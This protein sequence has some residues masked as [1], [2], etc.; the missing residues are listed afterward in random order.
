MKIFSTKHINSNQKELES[1]K[2]F[3]TDYKVGSDEFNFHLSNYLKSRIEITKKL[4]TSFPNSKI[5][6]KIVSKMQ[7]KEINEGS[8]I[9]KKG[10]IC[11]KFYFLLKGEC[12]VLDTKSESAIASSDEIEYYLKRLKDVKEYGLI[13]QFKK[14]NPELSN[15]FINNLFKSQNVNAI[16]SNNSLSGV[17]KERSTSK[18]PN[19]RDDLFQVD[20]KD[21]KRKG[22][23]QNF[24]N[25]LSTHDSLISAIRNYTHLSE[26]SNKD[27]NEVIKEALFSKFFTLEENELRKWFNNEELI[28]LY[29]ESRK[30]EN[31]IDGFTPA[32]DSKDGNKKS[33][34][35]SSM[36][37]NS[38]IKK[39]VINT[40]LTILE[41]F[42][43]KRLEK[44]EEMLNQDIETCNGNL[45]SKASVSKIISKNSVL[46]KDKMRSNNSSILGSL[47]KMNSSVKFNNINLSSLKKF[48]SRI[49]SVNDENCIEEINE[50][51]CDKA[52]NITLKYNFINNQNV[53]TD[54]NPYKFISGNNIASKKPSLS[55]FKKN[56][57][58]KSGFLNLTHSNENNEQNNNRNSYSNTKFNE[59]SLFKKVRKS[60][61]L[62]YLNTTNKNNENKKVSFYQSTSISKIKDDNKIFRE[63]LSLE[64]K[65]SINKSN[66]DGSLFF[67]LN[68]IKNNSSDDNSNKSDSK[69]I[70]FETKNTN[71]KEI[72]FN[73]I[74][75]ERN[76]SSISFHKHNKNKINLSNSISLNNKE[77]SK[78]FEK[79]ND[80]FRNK[81]NSK[82]PS[83]S[84][85]KLLSLNYVA[86]QELY[87]KR[88]SSMLE[89][90]QYQS[91]IHTSMQSFFNL[92]NLYNSKSNAK[93]IP[94]PGT[95][96]T[97]NNPRKINKSKN[98]NTSVDKSIKQ[99]ELSKSPIKKK[100]IFRGKNTNEYAIDSKLIASSLNKNNDETQLNNKDHD[101]NLKH[102]FNKISYQIKRII[103]KDTTFPEPEMDNVFYNETIISNSP[104]VMGY[105]KKDDYFSTVFL[106]INEINKQIQVSLST[107][108]LFINH[109][110]G[111]FY[112]SFQLL[113]GEFNSNIITENTDSNDYIYLLKS[114]QCCAEINI[115]L[116]DLNNFFLKLISLEAKRNIYIQEQ[117]LLYAIKHCSTKGEIDCL[118]E[119]LS[120]FYS[121][122]GKNFLFY[123]RKNKDIKPNNK[124]TK[125]NFKEDQD[126]LMDE[127]D[128]YELSKNA[129]NPKKGLKRAYIN[130]Y[131]NFDF[132]DKKKSVNLSEDVSYYSEDNDNENTISASRSNQKSTSLNYNVRTSAF[133]SNSINRYTSNRLVFNGRVK[134]NHLSSKNKDLH[135][136]THKNQENNDF[137][138]YQS[139]ISSK[140][141]NLKS[142]DISNEYFTSNL[143]N[144]ISSHNSNLKEKISHNLS[145]IQE[146]R[147]QALDYIIRKNLFSSSN[148]EYDDLL[149]EIEKT[150]VFEHQLIKLHKLRDDIPFIEEKETLKLYLISNSEFFNFFETECL[151][152]L[153]LKKILNVRCLKKS[154]YLRIQKKDFVKFL[155]FN[156]EIR[157]RAFDY[158]YFKILSVFRRMNYLKFQKL[159][160]ISNTKAHE[161]T[162][163]K[164]KNSPFNIKNLNNNANIIEEGNNN[165]IALF[166]KN[167]N[168]TDG[169]YSSFNIDYKNYTFKNVK[170]KNNT[171]V[172][173]AKRIVNNKIKYNPALTNFDYSFIVQR[174]SKDKD[175]SRLS[176]DLISKEDYTQENRKS[177]G[178]SNKVSHE[179]TNNSVDEITLKTYASKLSFKSKNTAKKIKK[180]IKIIN[181]KDKVEKKFNN[182][183][184]EAY[185]SRLNFIKNIAINNSENSDSEYSDNKGKNTNRSL[186]SQTRNKTKGSNI[187]KKQL[188]IKDLKN[189]FNLTN[190]KQNKMFLRSQ[191]KDIGSILISSNKNIDTNYTNNAKENFYF[192]EDKNISN[193]IRFKV[194]KGVGTS[195]DN[196]ETQFKITNLALVQKDLNK[197][198]KLA[199]K[200]HNISSIIFTKKTKNKKKKAKS[201]ANVV[202]K[203]KLYK[204]VDESDKEFN[205]FLKDLFYDKQL[206]KR[207]KINKSS[208]NFYLKHRRNN[209]NIL[210]ALM[211]NTSYNNSRSKC[212]SRNERSTT[213]TKSFLNIN[214]SR[215][216]LSMFSSNNKSTEKDVIIENSNSKLIFPN[217]QEPL[218]SQDTT[219]YNF[220]YDK[221]EKIE[222]NNSSL[223]NCIN[224]V[225][226]KHG[227]VNITN[228]NNDNINKNSDS[229]K[230]VFSNQQIN[231]SKFLNLQNSISINNL[232]S[233][234]ISDLNPSTFLNK[235]I[236]SNNLMRGKE[237]YSKSINFNSNN[238]YINEDQY[239]IHNYAHKSNEMDFQKLLQSRLQKSKR[240]IFQL[241]KTLLL[242]SGSI[243][244]N[245]ILL[246]KNRNSK[247]FNKDTLSQSNSIINDNT[248]SYNNNNNNSID[249]KFIL[250]TELIRSL[251]KKI[252]NSEK[253]MRDRFSYNFDSKTEGSIN[254]SNYKKPMNVHLNDNILNIKKKIMNNMNTSNTNNTKKGISLNFNI[255]IKNT[256]ENNKDKKNDIVKDKK[257]SFP[258]IFNK[259]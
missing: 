52:N 132:I 46:F 253:K 28:D 59:E 165:N 177:I 106:F 185:E 69:R 93:L 176:Y 150:F 49:M 183:Y 94:K 186:N 103:S 40:F 191:T 145:Y 211:S 138:P 170:T 25:S 111:N 229:D 157:E 115:S 121:K 258:S 199:S 75:D 134:N 214:A 239:F 119:D 58:Q 92:T 26:S 161:N 100:S 220:S 99:S 56:S 135:I 102:F 72:F 205:K 247:D 82:S 5:I 155:G 153:G 74:K 9:F 174:D 256:N 68:E 8:V 178:K 53:G 242:K 33:Y 57:Q 107:H 255:N 162:G 32:S 88:R 1:I 194:D 95:S 78:A 91:E 166:S 70:R 34:R 124:I 197:N 248:F 202:F 184:E 122:H 66:F 22:I 43:L 4:S 160:E 233:N 212:S 241:N 240:L 97:N 113:E 10:D 117:K 193:N 36:S 131:K 129:G 222:E 224:I 204:K 30:F 24:N 42:E 48:S 147:L 181:S 118:R 245:I 210:N 12:T 37:I 105:L 175:N 148:E 190:K 167:N 173:K 17:F 133:N 152:D 16:I 179:E 41:E 31:L 230:F 13:K 231:S 143:P 259:K 101:G 29:I 187:N 244:K 7:F 203:N 235:N 159:E 149:N 81:N 243:D 21:L 221:L 86:D 47:K 84:N 228:F 158:S 38:M 219:N 90:D 67:K 196:K 11:D 140:F 89:I 96:N 250:D 65:K 151:L 234:I 200:T 83:H 208:N 71:S 108:S 2:I 15:Q 223:V 44:E 120:S 163:I 218:I 123:P 127:F 104:I 207:L 27:D 45:K 252:G 87:K 142:R 109:S 14:V 182:K 18:I 39:K 237:K 20:I 76:I 51:Y 125:T 236:N 180:N 55:A 128:Y 114:G 64:S 227:L 144:I 110:L 98:T 154:K 62:N 116:C 226:N 137:N 126:L 169:N 23:N 130:R 35:E 172:Q 19:F 3:G 6:E 139:N 249:R 77:S 188:N 195:E 189:K 54:Y 238:K 257:V 61:Y 251:N 171:T 146:L 198:S 79:K 73:Q 156:Q 215:N 80:V 141:L 213:Q 217:N 60:G 50:N 232:S 164:S 206:L 246:F 225:K 63:D 85:Q 209:N 192:K 168:E 112:K 216:D 254:L 136:K 201:S